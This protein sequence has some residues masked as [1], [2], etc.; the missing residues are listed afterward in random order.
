[1]GYMQTEGRLLRSEHNIL[2][3]AFIVMASSAGLQQQQ[4]VL[5]WLLEPLSQQWIQLEW[6]NKYLSEP[7]GVVRLCLDTQLMWS[8]FHTVMFLEKA[9]KRSGYRKGGSTTDPP[10]QH[11]LSSHL[12]WMLPPLLKL[13]RAVHALWSPSISQTLPAEVKA[14]MVITDAEKFSLLGGANPKISKST[15]SEEVETNEAGIRNWLKGIR[16]SGYN[17]L[18][19]AATVRESFF[20]CVDVDSFSLALMENIQSMEFR[21]LKQLIHSI[22]IPLV[23]FCPPEA[24]ETWLEKLLQPLFVHLQQ[25]LSFSWS[26]LLHEGRAKVPD[27]QGILAAPDMKV[28]VM[29]EKLLRDLTREMCTLLSVIASSGLNAGIPSLE[30]FGNANRV[31]TSSLTDLDAFLPKSMVAFVLQRNSLAIPALQICLEAFMWTDSESMTKVS[32]FC[33]AVVVLA[34]STRNVELRQFVCKDL[35]SAAIKGLALESNAI[36]SADLVGLCR[37]IFV[38]LCDR[39]PA[40]RQI[41]LSLPCISQQDL[42]AFQEALTKTSSPKEQKQHMKSLLMLATGNQLKALMAAQKSVNVITDVTA[43]PRSS[44]AAAREAR[45]EDDGEPVGLAAIL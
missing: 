15:P 20:K 44:N 37:D 11:P 22:L 27:I 35:F 1:M 23:K 4:E 3:E 26:G 29:E 45:I 6:Q 30:P 42:A 33:S 40:P 17:V 32:S 12:A 8:I 28:E 24:W 21:H 36:I 16:D 18:G 14:A 34:I 5:K 2:G 39:D 19:L 10:M 41:L 25:V 7:S 9:L 13:L 43:R 31:D 38:Y